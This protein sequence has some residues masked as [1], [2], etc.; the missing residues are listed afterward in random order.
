MENARTT[1]EWEIEVGVRVG[2][3]NRLGEA[4]AKPVANLH[5][6]VGQHSPRRAARKGQKSGAPVSSKATGLFPPTRIFESVRRFVHVDAR[7]DNRTM[8]RPRFL[9][10]DGIKECAFL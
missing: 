2:V 3:R 9:R 8:F 5:G 4:I 7:I 10:C 1:P 6:R